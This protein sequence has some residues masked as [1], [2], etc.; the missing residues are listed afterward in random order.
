MQ[1]CN[2]VQV[3]QLEARN[4]Q[5]AQELER[6]KREMEKTKSEHA[7]ACIE[8]TKSCEREI[9]KISQELE[10]ASKKLVHQKM[11]KSEAHEELLRVQQDNDVSLSCTCQ[12]KSLII[13]FLFSVSSC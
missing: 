1:A 11:S 3:T 8:Q 5:L 4:K 2:N 6:V 12:L 10:K 13:L 7:E 9:K